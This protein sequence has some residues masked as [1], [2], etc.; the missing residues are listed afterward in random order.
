MAYST[1]NP[2]VC[3]AQPVGGA[4]PSLWHY[5]SADSVATVTAAGYFSNGDALGMK[6]GDFVLID[7]TNVGD[8]GIAKV[9]S[10]AAGGAAAALESQSITT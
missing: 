2:P 3:L 6:V 8:G 4:G 7:D 10:V 1:S 5:S 9:T